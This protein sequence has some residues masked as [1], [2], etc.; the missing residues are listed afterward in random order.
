MRDLKA[1][2]IAT[3]RLL[4]RSQRHCWQKNLLRLQPLGEIGLDY[5]YLDHA[6]KN[7]QQHAFRDQLELATQL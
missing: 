5:I 6:D 3:L 1:P 2:K 4:K 7:A